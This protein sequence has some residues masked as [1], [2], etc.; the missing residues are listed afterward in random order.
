[1]KHDTAGP[2]FDQKVAGLLNELQVFDVYIE[3]FIEYKYD[4][5]PWFVW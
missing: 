4:Q 3:L 5:H 1:M 2:I